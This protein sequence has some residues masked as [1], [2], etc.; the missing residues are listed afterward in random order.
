MMSLWTKLFGK[1]SHTVEVRSRLGLVRL[2]D[3]SLPS[4]TLPEETV[5]VAPMLPPEQP[6]TAAP[7]ADPNVDAAEPGGG[8]PPKPPVAGNTPAAPTAT[9]DPIPDSEKV[10]GS[11]R[12]KLNQE[13]K[14]QGTELP[15]TW[16]AHHVYQ[17][18]WE[19]I[20]KKLKIDWES[21]T[22]GRGVPGTINRE[23]Y[24]LYLAW[25]KK[26]CDN[27]VNK[28]TLEN[29]TKLK[30]AIDKVYKD[31][32][33]LPTDTPDQVKQKM[34]NWFKEVHPTGKI[35][36]GDLDA[37]K[38]KQDERFKKIWDIVDGK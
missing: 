30:D 10:G 15:D 23:F 35:V 11:F 26:Y 9:P 29:F 16:E 6:A 12:D 25:L 19:A 5:W 17:Q 7:V 8:A 33:V 18:E 14:K 27:D 31:F 20:W 4:V 34:E 2:D 38:K 3:R 32:M 24:R 1:Q 37:W 28:I 13:L 22:N 36:D 21:G